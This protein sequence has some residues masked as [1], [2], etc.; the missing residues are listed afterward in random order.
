M[1]YLATSHIECVMVM[2]GVYKKQS[3]EAEVE[4]VEWRMHG[5]V[6]DSSP[7][8]EIT[9]FQLFFLRQNHTCNAKHGRRSR[10]SGGKEEEEEAIPATVVEAEGDGALTGEVMVGDESTRSNSFHEK[11]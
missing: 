8:Y 7:E 5:C 9:H 6:F 4:V 11:P 10:R 3:E 1:K 2:E